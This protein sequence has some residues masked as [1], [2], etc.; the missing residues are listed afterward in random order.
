MRTKN[1]KSWGEITLTGNLQCI[2]V[3]EKNKSEKSMQRVT[4]KNVKDVR[5]TRKPHKTLYKNLCIFVS[6]HSF[7]IY[8]VRKDPALPLGE[9][10]GSVWTSVNINKSYGGF[11]S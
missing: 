11:E 4:C 9:D 8:M 6:R 2:V 5:K 7:K 3:S 10:S 1:L